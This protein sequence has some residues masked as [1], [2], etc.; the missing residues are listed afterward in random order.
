LWVKIKET[1]IPDVE[2]ASP[3]SDR[4]EKIRFRFWY[5]DR[6][7]LYDDEANLVDSGEHNLGRIPMIILRNK[8]RAGG[9]IQG[10]SD[11]ANVSILNKQLYNLCSELD[12]LL[13]KATFPLLTYPTERA[14][15]VEGITLGVDKILT[16]DPTG[17][18]R[19]EYLSP[20]STSMDVYEKRIDKIIEEIFRIASLK[21]QGGVSPSGVAMTYEFENTQQII[22]GKSKNLEDAEKEI[23]SVLLLWEGEDSEKDDTTIEYASDFNFSNL[24]VDLHVALD[25]VM[26]QVSDT[27][28]KEYKKMMTRKLLPNL[29]KDKQETIDNEID[30]DIEGN[31][32][33]EVEENT[34][35]VDRLQ[36]EIA[37]T[38]QLQARINNTRNG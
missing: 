34:R 13:S 10:I 36:K 12:E 16:F 21:F 38:D 18:H 15:D 5:K 19:P 25:A 32:D 7:E 24:Q 30:N 37:L 9:D 22:K 4:E 11:V 27:F 31:I 14:G 35:E 29:T 28:N 20:Q 2:K 6:W 23:V 26:L 3:F 1:Y 8:K 33:N 17:Q